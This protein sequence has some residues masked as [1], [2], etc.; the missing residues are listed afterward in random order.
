MHNQ[1]APPPA[2]SATGFLSVNSYIRV[3]FITRGGWRK[4]PNPR[5]S[6]ASIIEKNHKSSKRN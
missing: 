1:P 6:L 2:N 5:I 4:A 3:Y